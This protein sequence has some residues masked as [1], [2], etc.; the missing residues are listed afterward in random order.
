MKDAFARTIENGPNVRGK[1]T[2]EL[3]MKNWLFK[4]V[5]INKQ[6]NDYGYQTEVL[7]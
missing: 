6:N 5:L 3:E 7:D 2:P 4:D 1:I